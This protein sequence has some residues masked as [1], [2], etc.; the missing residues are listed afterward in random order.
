MG[1]IKPFKIL[2]IDA[3]TKWLSKHKDIGDQVVL[4]IGLMYLSAYIK[5]HLQHPVEVKL[6]NTLVDIDDVEDIK[7]DIEKF[8]PDLVGIRVLSVNLKFFEDMLA[9]FPED[10]TVVVGGPHAN[11]EPTK[12]LE[13]PK[14]DYIVL[15]E[16]EETFLEL[17]TAIIE[18]RDVSGL[19]G[20]G[21]KAR[22]K[23]TINPRRPFIEDLDS[24]PIPDY[25]VVDLDKYAKYLTYGYTF[26]RQG[27][28][29]TSRGCPFN[30]NYCFNFTG[31]KFRKRSAQNV[32]DEIKYLYDNNDIRD[33]F[34]VDD[35]FNVD[36]KR[37]MEIFRLI[38]DSGIK[39]NLYFTAGLRGDLMDEEFID[40]M[41]EAGT[42]WVTFGVETVNK[43]VQKVANRIMNVE[44]VK[45]SIKYC[46]EKGIMVG[47]FFMV[48]FPTETKDEA[49]ETLNFIK[50]LDRI[51]MPYLFGV[52]YFPGTKLFEIADELNIITPEQMENIYIPYHEVGAHR[53]DAMSEMDFK[54][55]FIY[56]MRE[57]F[58]NKDRLRNAVNN[59]RKYL[60]E[61]EINM[62]YSIFLSRR[63]ESPEA[64]FKL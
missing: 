57:I 27:I 62:L 3:N 34:I 6:V 50:D 12:V 21:Y 54:G 59:Q 13:Y 15:N 38:I 4:P 45:Q 10:L 37:S 20:V 49:M 52:K 32:F 25:S 41:V 2:L 48:G 28:I 63:I 17:V 61:E 43:R 19:K 30:C 23:P 29:L 24:L 58:L 46:C 53:T 35:T 64:A 1:A 44:K 40:R 39:I 36:R 56:Y 51:T 33:F 7:K 47:A 9:Q 16:G 26:R 55:I 31:R 8:N 11:L 22:S 14:V 42:I 18:K 5:E 60:S